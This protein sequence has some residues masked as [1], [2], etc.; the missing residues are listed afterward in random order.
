VDN[1]GFVLAPLP[2]APLNET[3]TVL[4]P[5]GLNALKRVARLTDVKI[6]GS[7][8]NLDGGFESRHNRKAI[9]NAGLSAGRRTFA[10]TPPA[11]RPAHSP[12]AAFATR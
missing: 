7:Y 11:T 5:E 12:S 6:D 10:K 1:N 4:P 9:F 8:R 2:V 3:D